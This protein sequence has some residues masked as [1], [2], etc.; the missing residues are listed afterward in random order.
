MKSLFTLIF[1]LVV[2][3][4]APFAYSYMFYYAWEWFVA[5]VFSV[6]P[7]Q[8]EIFGLVLMAGAVKSYLSN[9]FNWAEKYCQTKFNEDE[10]LDT[11][12]EKLLTFALVP[13]AGLG[14]CSIYHYW[15]FPFFGG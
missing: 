7:T 15:L 11:C 2:F 3:V 8:L 9:P 5:P 13:W 12:C 4:Y 14:I 1:A 10:K 6:Q